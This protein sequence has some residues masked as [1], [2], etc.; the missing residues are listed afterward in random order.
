MERKTVLL[1]LLKQAREMEM[2][3]VDALSGQERARTGTLED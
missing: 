2:D 3:F 1:D